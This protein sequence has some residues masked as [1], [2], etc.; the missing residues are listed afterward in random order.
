MYICF[1]I[2]LFIMD[3]IWIHFLPIRMRNK[4]VTSARIY[5]KIFKKD[6]LNCSTINGTIGDGYRNHVYVNVML[7]DIHV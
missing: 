6:P 2:S 4:V 5:V 1:D 7:F 3:C